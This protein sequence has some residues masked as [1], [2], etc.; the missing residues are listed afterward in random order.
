VIHGRGKDTALG[1]PKT[2]S[3]FPPPRRRS[4]EVSSTKVCGGEKET[5]EQ[6]NGVTENL[7]LIMPP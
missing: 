2:L 6:S 3:T 5:K 7:M 1:K 4:L